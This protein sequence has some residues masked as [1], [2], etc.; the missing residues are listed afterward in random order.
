MAPPS[1]HVDRDARGI[2]RLRSPQALGP[3]A[4]TVSEWLEVWA[5]RTPDQ[6]FLAER[7]PAGGWRRMTYAAAHDTVLRLAQGLLDADLDATR[8]LMILSENSIDHGM[9]ALAAMHIGVPAVPVSVAYSLQDRSF[10]KVRHIA[11]LVRPGLVYASDRQRY[12]AALDA[13]GA[14][15]AGIDELQR[16]APSEHVT[17]AHA[18][19]GPD[20][21]AKIL[22]TSGSTGHPKGVINT[23]R[24]LTV[25]QQQ[26]AQVWSFLT[27]ESPVVI[28]WLPWNHTFGG[29]YN[30]NLVHD[31]SAMGEIMAVEYLGCKDVA[32]MHG[33]Q[34]NRAR[35]RGDGDDTTISVE[36]MATQVWAREGDGRW[37][38]VAF[39]ATSLG[40]PPPAVA[41]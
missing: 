14:A 19:T 38:L 26:A 25:N 1:L 6:V 39:H 37:R 4:A 23:Q 11:N 12:A 3:H 33:K 18:L 21:V 22:F 30:F 27:H 32:V 8:P 16:K 34:V 20:T 10:E 13:V 15:I 36:A 29:N 28:D 40:P 5:A 31:A 35:L 9:L 17:Q 24:M 7:E 41:R 2:V